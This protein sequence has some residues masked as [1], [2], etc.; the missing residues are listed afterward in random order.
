LRTGKP[1]P[2][3]Y[4]TANRIC[5][6]QDRLRLPSVSARDIFVCE[7]G[8]ERAIPNN[9]ENLQIF[10]KKFLTSSGIC[11]KESIL[12]EFAWLSHRVE[13]ACEEEGGEKDEEEKI[14]P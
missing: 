12:S 4:T 8:G 10:L 3:H 1:V 11:G 13:M 2:I 7:Q 14:F 9:L 6:Q 5:Q